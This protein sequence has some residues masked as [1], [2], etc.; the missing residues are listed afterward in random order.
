MSIG[1]WLK[2]VIYQSIR[3]GDRIIE[4]QVS[5]LIQEKSRKCL[6]ICS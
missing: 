6:V 4:H 5:G 2:S 1:A 3:Q